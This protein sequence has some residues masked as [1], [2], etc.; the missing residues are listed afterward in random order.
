MRFDKRSIRSFLKVLNGGHVN[1]VQQ[2]WQFIAFTPDGMI[3]MAVTGKSKLM[4]IFLLYF[5]KK[6]N[7]IYNYIEVL[8]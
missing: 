1:G 6:K 7:Y 2:S 5:Q 8:Q 3:V 4:C